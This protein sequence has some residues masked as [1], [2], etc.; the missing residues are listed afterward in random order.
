MVFAD[1]NEAYNTYNAYAICK[2]FGVRKGQKTN[3][4]KGVLR[5]CT[6]VCN[7]EGHSPPISPHKQR[8]VYRT[9]KRTGCQAC[10]KFKIED[11][12]WEVTKFEDVHNHPFIDDK[13]KH[14][15]RSYR[16][17]T[18]T[19][20]GILTSMTEAGIRAT[21]AYSYLCDEAGGSNN[22]GFTLHDC[23]N[24]LQT[25]R[26][27]LICAGD[28][29][30]LINHFNYLQSNGSN[31]FHTF[32]L[33]EEQ[34]LT[35]VFWSDGVSKLDYESFGDVVVF[36]TTYRTNKY[37]MICAPFVGLNHHWKNVL[38]GCAFLMDEIVGSFVWAFRSFLEVM[39]NKAPK[40]IFT[41]QDHAMANAIRTVFPNSD[42]RLCIWHIG[43]NATQH[44]S[45]L[46]GKPSFRDKYWHKVLYHCES[47][48]EMESTWKAMCEEWNLGDNKWLDN[49]YRLHHKW[50]P[51]F[52]RDFFS[53]GIRST[54]RSESTNSVFQEMACKSM[55]L[56][57]FVIH[58]EKQLEKMRNTEIADDFEC[59]RGKPYIMV[60]NSG[61]LQ[62]AAEVYTHVIYR[63]FQAEFLH[64][65]SEHVLRSET[66]GPLHTYIVGTGSS[67][68][69][70]IVHF[71]PSDSTISCSCKLFEMQGWL[72]RHALCVLTNVAKVTNI[73]TKYI[74]KRWTKVAKQGTYCEDIA[75]SSHHAVKSKTLRLKR[76]MQLAFNVMNDCANHDVTEELAT[77]TLLHL[78]S[79]RK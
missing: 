34:R 67:E 52:G 73:P 1:E 20:K 31:F 72:C 23:Q 25:K 69:K 45:H 12:V 63:N 78:E 33:D 28:C 71:C 18:D 30:G 2:G 32:Q 70:H 24:F 76:L 46:L 15:I 36:D 17:I 14:L 8:D 9:V 19:S 48:I 39:G 27:N 29:Q 53:A 22:I 37:N 49:M 40:T 44:I 65:L 66:D 42:H 54:Q 61:I 41:D 26:M 58:Y 62:H 57:E 47:E 21:K 4:S 11:G 77:T 10:I 75:Q 56:S 5:R 13:Q 38:F 59:A 3:N 43:K 51:A 7:C 64:V 68:R 60:E 6:F 55:T 74:L 79:Q 16:H 50:C 35:N